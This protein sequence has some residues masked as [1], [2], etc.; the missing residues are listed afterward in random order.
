MIVRHIHVTGVVQGVG[1]RPFV[2]QIATRA[3]LNG[4]VANT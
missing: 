4:W 3:N 2:Y 1:F